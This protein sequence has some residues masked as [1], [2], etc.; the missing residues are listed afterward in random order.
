MTYKEACEKGSAI[1]EKAGVQEAALDARL[2]L[3]HVC[4]T[5]RNFLLVHGDSVLEFE[6]RAAYFE[7]VEKRSRR[8]P[9]Q[10]LTGVQYFMGL[11]FQ[12]DENVLI[13]RQDTEILAE[14]VLRN[15]HDGMRVL[16]MCTGSGCILISLLHYTN[17]CQGLGADISS[18]ALKVAEKN[19]MLLLGENRNMQPDDQGLES[20]KAQEQL[21]IRF[22]ESNLFE[23]VDGI[24]DIVVSNPPYI[25]SE[26]IEGLMPEVR[27]HE[28]RLALDG[29][30]DGLLF[31]RR[32]IECCKDHLTRGGML[33]LEIG[34]T[35]GEAVSRMMEQAGFLDI[36]VK[37]DY[38]GLD[39]VVFGT[40]S[41][42]L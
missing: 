31:Y 4:G 22:V 40:L 42:E 11:P 26:E 20:E 29:G 38:A 23:K 25:P 16:D 37:K 14:E 18:D 5:D 35:Q 9:L 7:L 15:L 41:F 32:I 30:D 17:D 10:Q 19:A 6:K 27:D 24:F 39:R 21:R 1:L 36:H 8:L 2:L 3:E 34:Y 33:F 12:V 28:P 13:P